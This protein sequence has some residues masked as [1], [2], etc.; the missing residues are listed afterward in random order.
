MA[1]RYHAAESRLRRLRRS[2]PPRKLSHARNTSACVCKVAAPGSVWLCVRPL[3]HRA[4]G[5]GR[6]PGLVCDRIAASAP[7]GRAKACPCASWRAAEPISEADQRPELWCAV[8]PGHHTGRA[9]LGARVRPGWFVQ[10]H[11]HPELVG[12]TLLEILAYDDGSRTGLHV[13]GA[14]LTLLRAHDERTG[15]VRDRSRAGS[16]RPASRSCSSNSPAP[17]CCCST[18]QPT[19]STLSRGPGSSALNDFEGTVRR[20]HP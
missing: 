5:T 8:A 1:S 7:M 14:W 20:R 9:R 10:T 4:D 18:S 15:A 11:E 13:F 3:A 12:R 2:G 17:I 6:T 16:S 19:T